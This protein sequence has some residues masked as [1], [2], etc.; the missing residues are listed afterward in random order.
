MTRYKLDLEYAKHPGEHPVSIYLDK[1]NI[2]PK[3]YRVAE[4]HGR[5]LGS[6]LRKMAKRIEEEES[7]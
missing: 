6:L 1:V 4:F 3:G 5:S 7:A 2:D